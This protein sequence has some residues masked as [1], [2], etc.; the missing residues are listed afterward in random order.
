MRA[1]QQDKYDAI[2]RYLHENERR[3]KSWLNAPEPKELHS[4]PDHR[5]AVPLK[6]CLKST[7]NNFPY[8]QNRY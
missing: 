6:S 7:N 8:Q 2:P 5:T 1:Q 3:I 4:P